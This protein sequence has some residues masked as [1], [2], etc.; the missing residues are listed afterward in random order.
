MA[1]YTPRGLKIRLP[2]EY[3]FA[4]MARLF[5]RKDAFRVLQMTEEV[6]NLASLAAFLAGV[7]VFVARLNP[8]AVGLVVG[9]TCLSFNVAHLV[10]LFYPPF[11]LLLP[12]S[13][14]YSWVSGYGILLISLLVL[15]FLTVGW[16]GV[17]A[18]LI[19]R[20][21]AAC[22]AGAIDLVYGKFV[23][24]KA[25]VAITKSERSFFHAY[26]LLADQIGATRSLEVPDEEMNPENWM[27]V[28]L[29]LM[30]KWPV[31]VARFTPD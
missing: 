29:D 20:I 15:G 7:I 9:L 30:T 21:A 10:G 23:F 16:Q 24:K 18:F 26:R 13:R 25:G 3:A 8:L 27:P 11:G 1:I 22:I 17:V 14:V 2:R 6:D 4:L 28:Y 31:V 5:P 19:A 12:L